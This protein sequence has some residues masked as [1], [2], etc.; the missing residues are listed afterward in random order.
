LFDETYEDT[1]G[2]QEDL[3]NEGSDVPLSDIDYPAPW[4]EQIAQAPADLCD[5]TGLGVPVC[6]RE[7]VDDHDRP[8][9]TKLRKFSLRGT[10]FSSR[11]RFD[12]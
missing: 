9:P 12:T 1:F 4:G 11:R 3:W 7:N 6:A 2:L 10:M 8:Y 5:E